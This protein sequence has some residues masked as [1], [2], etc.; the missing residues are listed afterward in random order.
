MRNSLVA[1]AALVAAPLLTPQAAQAQ[2]ASVTNNIPP[3]PGGLICVGSTTL[4][5]PGTGFVYFF[6]SPAPSGQFTYNLGGSPC[7]G[8]ITAFTVTAGGGGG[9]SFH[10]YQGLYGG[11]N[12][13]QF[14]AVREALDLESI[15]PEG[16]ARFDLESDSDTIGVTGTYFEADG[17]TEGGRLEARYERNF[18][19]FEGSRT[20]A[21]ITVPVQAITVDNKSNFNGVLAGG[22]EVPVQ[23]NW[24]LTP[25]LA[26]GASSGSDYF[27][28]DGYVA[29]A[30]LTSRYRFAQVGRGDLVLGNT[31][32]VTTES[33][34]D[35]QNVVFR[36]GLA[37]QF[38]LQRRIMGRQATAR[39]SY[40]NTRIEGDE[41]GIDDYHEIAFN[42]GVRQREQDVRNRFELIRVG[43]LVTLAD[44]D[45]RAVT[46]TVGVRF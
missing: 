35:T 46:G 12:S 32:L 18:R 45:Y 16:E 1:L 25:K 21:L 14:L 39:A 10:A 29:T 42:I 41:V 7:A 2:A 31:I 15:Q 30:S 8:T 37:Y 36:N 23:A 33:Q 28:G 5:T 3:P 11:P 9:G 27:G 13:A 20:R 44:F 43:V 22:F 17:G 38:N 34:N 40:V 4:T 6:V 19:P 26:V 24:S